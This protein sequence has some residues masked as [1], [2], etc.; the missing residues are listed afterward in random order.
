MGACCVLW[1]QWP[2]DYRISREIEL[3]IWFVVKSW[4]KVDFKWPLATQWFNEMVCFNELDMENL[5]DNKQVTFEDILIDTLSFDGTPIFIKFI[6]VPNTAEILN[7]KRWKQEI[8]SYLYNLRSIVTLKQQKVRKERQFLRLVDVGDSQFIFCGLL[9]RVFPQK[10][11]N[12]TTPL[13]KTLW[14]V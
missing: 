12:K 13:L 10:F 14:W 9:F 4:F 6:N 5:G 11:D 1:S 2:M 7:K 3:L 8:Y